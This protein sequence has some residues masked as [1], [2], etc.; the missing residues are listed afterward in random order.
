MAKK[1]RN[2][3]IEI[4]YSTEATPRTTTPD[5]I[6]VFCAYDE[7]IPANLTQDTATL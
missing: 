4:D 1:K 7:L 2:T 6:P 3:F 5:G